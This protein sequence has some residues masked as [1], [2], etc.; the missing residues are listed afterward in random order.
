MPEFKDLFEVYVH[1]GGK[2][3]FV[4]DLIDVKR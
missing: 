3:S 2:V 1:S 4:A